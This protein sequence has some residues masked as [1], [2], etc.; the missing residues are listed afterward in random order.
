[1]VV[2]QVVHPNRASVLKDGAVPRHAVRHPRDQLG[3]VKRRVRIMT[4]AEQQHLSIQV[5]HPADRAFGNVGR[6]GKRARGD[7]GSLG[8]GRREGLQVTAAQHTG[9]SPEAVGNDSQVGRRAGSEW[10]EGFLVVSGPGRHGQRAVRAEGVAKGIDQAF[11]SAL[12]GTDGT[13]GGVY[14]QDTALL[15]PKPTEL[16]RDLGSAQLRWLDLALRASFEDPLRAD[17]P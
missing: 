12:D 16:L 14:Q 8:S 5:V 4:D 13:K 6:K 10:I 1:M 11:G 2:L 9:Q 15:D 3:Q 17:T 7:A